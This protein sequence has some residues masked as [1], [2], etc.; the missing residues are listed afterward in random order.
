[1]MWTWEMCKNNFKGISDSACSPPEPCR[2]HWFLSLPSAWFHVVTDVQVSRG[3]ISAF[4]QVRARHGAAQGGTNT[5]SHEELKRGNT[6]KFTSGCGGWRV[7]LGCL[8]QLTWSSAPHLGE[9][10]ALRVSCLCVGKCLFESYEENGS[11]NSIF[12]PFTEYPEM[13]RVMSILWGVFEQKG[14]LG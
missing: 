10:K 8:T 5:K 9:D 6:A 3:S 11:F 13:C 1:M 12:L 7:A 4:L 14:D 2:R